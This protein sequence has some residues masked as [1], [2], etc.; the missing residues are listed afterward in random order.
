MS[1]QSLRYPSCESGG[2]R[3]RMAQHI[4]WGGALIGVG[5]PGGA[6][7]LARGLVER[8]LRKGELS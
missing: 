2:P 3:K 4:S 1:P 8:G 6:V 5:A 7:V